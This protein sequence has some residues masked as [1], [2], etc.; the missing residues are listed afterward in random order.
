MRYPLLRLWNNEVQELLVPYLR[1][2]V[3]GHDINEESAM[4]ICDVAL[5]SVD[6]QRM[7]EEEFKSPVVNTQAFDV[8]SSVRIFIDGAVMAYFFRSVHESTSAVLNLLVNL[9]RVEIRQCEKDFTDN[10]SLKRK[11]KLN[12]K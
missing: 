8:V 12:S 10:L 11:L 7:P 3:I 1:L 5:Q 2:V 6:L 4:S 9:E